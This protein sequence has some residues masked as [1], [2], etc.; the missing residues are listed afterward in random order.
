MQIEG[1]AVAAEAFNTG[2]CHRNGAEHTHQSAGA[3][4]KT[5]GIQQRNDAGITQYGTQQKI[6]NAAG[7]G[8]G[9]VGLIAVVVAGI[10]ADKPKQRHSADAHQHQKNPGR[11]PR[12]V[13]TLAVQTAGIHPHP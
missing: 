12:F 13:Q 6:T 3:A 2:G 8:S 11:M 4:E 1:G 5:R 7:N 10:L 9:E